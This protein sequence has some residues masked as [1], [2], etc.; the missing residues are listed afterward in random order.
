[1]GKKDAELCRILTG[2]SPEAEVSEEVHQAYLGLFPGE[3]TDAELPEG[4]QPLAEQIRQ[5][6]A[7]KVKGTRR[8]RTLAVFKHS[9]SRILAGAPFDVPASRRPAL[10]NDLLV[11]AWLGALHNELHTLKWSLYPLL[12]ELNAATDLVSTMGLISRDEP[13]PYGPLGQ[14]LYGFKLDESAGG[15]GRLSLQSLGGDPHTSTVRLGDIVALATAGVRRSVLGLSATAFFPKA[16]LQH[17]HALPAYVMTDA[18]PGAVTA[19]AGSVSATDTGWQPISIGGLEEKRKPSELRKLAEQ[20]WHTHLSSHLEKVAR[21]DPQRELALLVGNSYFHA[22]VTGAGIAAACGRPEWVAVLVSNSQTP[23]KAAVALPEGVVRVTIDE[24]EDLPA[25]HPRVKVI[26]APLPVVSRGLNILIPHTDRS[27]LASVWVGVRPI[28]HLHEPSVMYASI[29]A[30]GI[31]A[32]TVSADPAGMLASQRTAAIR[33]RELLLRTDPRFSRM[34]KFLKTEVLAGILVE[35]IQLAGRARRGGTPVEL[36]LVDHAFFNQQL[37]CDFPRLLRS[38]Y[39]QLDTDEQDLLRR[40]YGSTLTAWLDLAHSES[41]LPGPVT[42][43]PAP[44][45]DD[46]GLHDAAV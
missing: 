44:A 6:L 10:V 3:Q 14:N 22:E 25:T 18:A 28:T 20:L 29:N 7:G 23:S 27:A 17:V 42:L 30:C 41:P 5:A 4:W 2:A 37:G 8:S 38:Y 13:I 31:A 40:V 15:S 39:G 26:C 33:Q 43:I 12:G 45:P 1:M 32:G 34:P 19:H 24:L 16:A 21:N 11:R 36:Y 9:I 46:E 35:L